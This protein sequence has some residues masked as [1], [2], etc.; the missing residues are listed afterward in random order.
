MSDS[1]GVSNDVEIVQ[2]NRR[3]HFTNSIWFLLGTITTF[4]IVMSAIAARVYSGVLEIQPER[5]TE[6]ASNSLTIALLTSSSGVSIAFLFFPLNI[7][8]IFISLTVSF[9]TVYCT[10]LNTLLKI[11]KSKLFFHLATEIGCIF[12]GIIDL[13]GITSVNDKFIPGNKVHKML[14]YQ[15]G[16]PIG[17][18]LVLIIVIFMK[19]NSFRGRETRFLQESDVLMT[20]QMMILLL[21][22]IPILM[23]MSNYHLKSNDKQRKWRSASRFNSWKTWMKGLHMYQC[24]YAYAILLIIIESSEGFFNSSILMYLT[25]QFPYFKTEL[26]TLVIVV[27]HQVFDLIGRCIPAILQEIMGK[28]NLFLFRIR[29]YDEESGPG[30]SYLDSNCHLEEEKI[31]L[32]STQ[33]YTISKCV[34]TVLVG[35]RVLLLLCIFFKRHFDS[36]FPNFMN[37]FPAVILITMYNSLV[38]GAVVS[39]VY[40]QLCLV[41]ERNGPVTPDEQEFKAESTSNY[42]RKIEL[43]DPDLMI[44]L[45][46][47][48]FRVLETVPFVFWTYIGFKYNSVLM[49]C[50]L[51]YQRHEH[52]P[53]DALESDFDRFI[54]WITLIIS[55][56][57]RDICNPFGR[58]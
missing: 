32:K 19:I 25:D 54:W 37:S 26:K 5:S 51:Y 42:C 28:Y 44:S 35:V 50:E 45:I 11:F 49:D 13:I 55:K 39:L 43:V 12:L 48:A 4:G 27:L 40:T 1:G 23:V 3:L 18:L 34:I 9:A 31:D 53:T 16:R 58:L 52:W 47:A 7:L 24:I 41:V 2:S 8:L 46:I 38:R 21:L 14:S 30:K 22:G 20:Y 57:L 15:I 17:Y 29:S 33:T 10:L 6:F 36:Q 56:I